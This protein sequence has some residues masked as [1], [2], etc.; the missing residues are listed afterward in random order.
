MAGTKFVASAK[1]S[2]AIALS[3][4]QAP[5]TWGAVEH[6]SMLRYLVLACSDK[7][8]L[9]LDDLRRVTKGKDAQGKE[10]EVP[11]DCDIM[12]KWSVLREEFGQSGKLAECANFYKWL[13]ESGEMEKASVKKA[14][15]A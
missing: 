12:V 1:L 10:I 15:Y 6:L 8:K 4:E 9:G 5:E 7:A 3:V 13:Q 11:F 14:Q 2:S